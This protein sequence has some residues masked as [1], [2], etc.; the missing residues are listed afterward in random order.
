MDNNKIK[1]ES[2]IDEQMLVDGGEVP[3]EQVP[4]LN[5][6]AEPKPTVA[7]NKQDIE[8]KVVE[9]SPP[10]PAEKQQINK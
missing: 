3:A 2:N 6:T 5:P 9:E 10:R 8:M 4:E 7:P 1:K